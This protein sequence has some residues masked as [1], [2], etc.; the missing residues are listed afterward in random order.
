[1]ATSL[2]G[3]PIKSGFVLIGHHGNFIGAV[4]EDEIRAQRPTPRP[5]GDASR[6]CSKLAIKTVLRR[7]ALFL[8]T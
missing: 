8:D 3:V 5:V 6:N 1:L 4:I 7:I 2:G